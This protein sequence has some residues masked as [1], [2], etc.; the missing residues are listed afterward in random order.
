MKKKKY[1]SPTVTI[2]NIKS[3]GLIMNSSKNL[4]KANSDKPNVDHSKD[5]S[6]KDGDTFDELKE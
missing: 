2:N 5:S 4:P 6:T 3:E 1:I